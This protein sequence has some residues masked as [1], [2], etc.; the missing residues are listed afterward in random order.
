[1]IGLNSDIVGGRKVVQL[2]P[3]ART[4]TVRLPRR[5]RVSVSNLLRQWR[6]R[7]PLFSSTHHS[8]S[9]LHLMMGKR[10]TRSTVARSQPTLCLTQFGY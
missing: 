6:E 7:Q 9:C 10:S 4:I 8:H 2:L 1:M 5:P 3:C